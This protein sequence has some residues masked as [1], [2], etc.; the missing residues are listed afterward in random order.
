MNTR[1]HA[2]ATS[3]TAATT[4]S[5]AL[6]LGATALPATAAEGDGV[7][8]TTETTRNTSSFIEADPTIDPNTTMAEAGSSADQTAARM[9]EHGMFGAVAIA[10]GAMEPDTDPT[11]VSTVGFVIVASIIAAVGVVVEVLRYLGASVLGLV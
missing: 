8:T 9:K 4:L 1:R 5:L 10:L 3:V 7:D 2:T 6:C 11:V